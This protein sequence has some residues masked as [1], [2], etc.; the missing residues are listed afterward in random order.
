MEKEDSDRRR[1]QP[2]GGVLNQ[3]MARPSHLG[4]VDLICNNTGQR[5]TTGECSSVPMLY[6][7]AAAARQLTRAPPVRYLCDH[8][9]ELLVLLHDARSAAPQLLHQLPGVRRTHTRV[10]V[11]R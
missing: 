3:G 10:D 11:R 7:A 6:Y 2:W 8:C 1:A 9:S 4:V 5:R